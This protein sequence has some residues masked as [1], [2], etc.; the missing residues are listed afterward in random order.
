[1]NGWETKRKL[2]PN[3]KSWRKP[4]TALTSRAW[5]RKAF[6]RASQSDDAGIEPASARQNP[7]VWQR[8]P[9]PRY[10]TFWENRRSL[11]MCGRKS[12]APAS[13]VNGLRVPCGKFDIDND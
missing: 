12:D 4:S 10:K 7:R 5:P 8:H 11:Y 13:A 3:A 2:A 6:S 9:A 1:M